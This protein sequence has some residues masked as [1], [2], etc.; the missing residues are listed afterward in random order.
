MEITINEEF[1]VVCGCCGGELDAEVAHGQIVVDVCD[2]C[3][4]AAKQDVE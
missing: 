4:E 1:D 3:F 2:T